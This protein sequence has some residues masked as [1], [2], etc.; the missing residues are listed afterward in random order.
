LVAAWL[1][2]LAPTGFTA[3]PRSDLEELITTHVTAMAD[4]LAARP[5]SAM[6]AQRAGAALIRASFTDADCLRVSLRVLAPG[7]L[8]LATADGLP[9]P[10]DRAAAMLGGLGAGYAAELRDWLFDQQEEVK[11]ALQRATG[12][13]ERRLKRSEAWFREVFVRAA[14]GI[15][16]SDADGRLALVNPAL[17]DILGCQPDE[18]V[19]R[20]IEEFFHTQE[21]DDLRADYHDLGGIDSKPLRRRRRLVRTD[22]QLVWAYLAVSVL[23]DS[24]DVPTLHLTMV[25]NVSDLHLLQDLTSYQSLHDVLTGLPNRQ[26]LLSQ[27]QSQ[28]AGPSA[29]G[30]VTLYHLD[31]DGF[32][33]INRGLGPEHG[34]RLMLLTARRL[35]NQFVGQ[36]VLV[37][38]L[39]GDEFALL[40]SAGSDPAGV[41][42]TLAQINE[43]LA[44]PVHLPD[45]G[46]GLS[47]SI[48]VAHGVAGEID[49]FELLR[50]AEVSLRRAQTTGNRQWAEY[51]RHHDAIE[52]RD[53]T[54]AS[55]M[56][57]ALE[58]GQLSLL[59]Q[60][61]HLLTEDMVVGVS[62][63]AVWDHPEQGRID[64][65]EC[66]RLAE[67]TGA[68]VSFAAWLVDAATEQ[69]RMWSDRFGDGAPI[70]G[71]SLTTSQIV[72]P[73]LVATVGG[74]L[75]KTGIRP[76]L[77]CLGVPAAALTVEGGEA[78]ES[79]TVLTGM[80]VR[81]TLCDTGVVP[82]EL[83]LLDDWPITSVEMAPALVRRLAQ[84]D[85]PECRL[86]RTTAAL[87][88]TL[89]DTQLPV[90]V[91][92]LCTEREVAWWR[93][94]GAIS[95]SGPY[96]GEAVAADEL[97]PRSQRW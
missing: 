19:G 22:G 10:A 87:V 32:G 59:W 16:I 63:R 89:R 62:A 97:A 47:A 80:G 23:R 39:T 24:D 21:T 25:E 29:T 46:V 65:V 27:L 36:R 83:T 72:D 77:L 1:R 43:T 69:V 14:V 85:D 91:S 45:G 7:L 8:H 92:D 58:F 3:L 64:H 26:Y 61:W 5:L 52:R 13:T 30:H 73:D 50:R 95:G 74:A 88:G 48:G 9:D 81:I 86:A 38:R 15:A 90:V 51:D 96:F 40:F 42:T 66:L 6:P 4:G 57:G 82:V 84:L 20:S 67:M 18:L 56:S 49:P 31:L 35:E 79:I 53:A 11:Q 55:T 12:E 28:L 60:S 94:I 76:D 33:A 34:D 75:E 41:L 78:R 17:A 54:L 93:S 37:A 44:E 68:A 2:A 70:V 71:I